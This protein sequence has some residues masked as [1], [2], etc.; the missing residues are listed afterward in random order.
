[1]RRF[2]KSPDGVQSSVGRVYQ[3]SGKQGTQTSPDREQR[4]QGAHLLI[5]EK[6]FS[7]RFQNG[8]AR[9]ISHRELSG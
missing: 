4:W 6:E 9:W 8:V 3:H 1:M 7:R 2:A 5:A